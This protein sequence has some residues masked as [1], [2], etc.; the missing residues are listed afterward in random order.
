MGGAG[1]KVRQQAR[2]GHAQ[3]LLAWSGGLF[4]AIPI[5]RAIFQVPQLGA[6]TLVA[7]LGTSQMPTSVRADSHRWMGLAQCEIDSPRLIE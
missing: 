7:L 4:R 2:P 3:S 1:R 6:A 5:S